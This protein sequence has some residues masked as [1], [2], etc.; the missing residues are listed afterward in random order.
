MFQLFREYL[1]IHAFKM[2][3]IDQL[4]LPSSFTFEKMYDEYVKAEKQY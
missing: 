1:K 3:K 2:G 4:I